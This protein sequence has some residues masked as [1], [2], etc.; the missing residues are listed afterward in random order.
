MPKRWTYATNPD[1]VEQCAPSELEKLSALSFDGFWEGTM[2]VGDTMSSTTVI[3]SGKNVFHDG[4]LFARIKVLNAETCVIITDYEDV[5]GYLSTD[6]KA[7][8]WE[9]GDCWRRVAAPQS[10]QY[11]EAAS[12]YRASKVAPGQARALPV[13]EALLLRD[14]E[15][16]AKLLDGGT[17]PEQEVKLTEAFWE[18]M[19]WRPDSGEP[20]SIP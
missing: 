17:S 8:D 7:I 5:R 13:M 16:L 9:D 20:T 19:R 6:G 12:G 3:I 18:S 15:S 11:E 4:S 14:S 1:D 10:G 2:A